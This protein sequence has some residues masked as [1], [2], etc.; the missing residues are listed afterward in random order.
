MA[1]KLAYLEEICCEAVD[2]T[3]LSQD[4]VQMNEGS[5]KHGNNPSGSTKDGKLLD[6]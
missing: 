5:C 2:W 3:H 1:E 4:R 6:Y